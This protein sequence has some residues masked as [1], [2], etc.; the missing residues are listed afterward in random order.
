MARTTKQERRERTAE[1]MGQEWADE[2]HALV[3]KIRADRKARRDEIEPEVIALVE[4]LFENGHGRALRLREVAERY[5]GYIAGRHWSHPC[6]L[7]V[8]EVADEIDQRRMGRLLDRKD[9]R[10]VAR[11]VLRAMERDG[12]LG[13]CVVLNRHGKETTGYYHQSGPAAD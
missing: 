3:D 10:I 9:Q 8:S 2:H 5:G 1:L 11:K 13:S 7:T 4:K 12:R 6:Y